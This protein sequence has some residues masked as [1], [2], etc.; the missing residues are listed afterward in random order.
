MSGRYSN[1]TRTKVSVTLYLLFID[2]ILKHAHNSATR[3]TKPICSR[4]MLKTVC[5]LRFT[6][7]EAQ[8][9]IT[10]IF[11]LQCVFFFPSRSMKVS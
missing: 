6:Y 10:M 8:E 5:F 4:K 9:T 1:M 7:D 3:A 2:I 11:K